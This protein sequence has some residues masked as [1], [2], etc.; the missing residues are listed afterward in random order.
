MIP[1]VRL[2]R[3]TRQSKRCFLFLKEIEQ[4]DSMMKG[5]A[6]YKTKEG[7]N[8]WFAVTG[9]K[10]SIFSLKSIQNKI[11]PRQLITF[12]YLQ[13]TKTPIYQELRTIVY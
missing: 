2:P 10:T 4:Q 6:W 11:T 9:I 12:L 8:F 13:F 7:D 5:F 3:R 1:Y